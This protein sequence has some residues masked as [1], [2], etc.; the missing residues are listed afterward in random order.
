[1]ERSQAGMFGVVGF[2][3]RQHL[4]ADDKG[5]L[6]QAGQ[7]GIDIL[8]AFDDQRAGGAA[9]HLALGEAMRVG[10]VPVESWGLVL[11][12]LHV[13]IEALARLDQRVDHLILPA[14]RRHVLVPWKWML[15]AVAD[16]APLQAL[17]VLVVASAETG[18]SSCR[19]YCHWRWRGAAGRSF[20]K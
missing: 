5:A 15:V 17:L 4:V 2:R 11:R 16:I 14:D 13:V 9:L 1:M 10:M 12:N 19:P 20:W 8:Q 6:G 3:S 7:C 18:S